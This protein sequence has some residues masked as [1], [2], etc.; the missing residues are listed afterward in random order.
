MVIGVIAAKIAEATAGVVSEIT[1][2]EITETVTGETAVEETTRVA[3][4]GTTGMTAAGEAP[5]EVHLQQVIFIMLNAELT[6]LQIISA[7]A[8]AEIASEVVPTTINV[9]SLHAMITPRH[10]GGE[11]GM[12]EAVAGMTEAMKPARGTVHAHPGTMMVLSDMLAKCQLDG[13]KS[14]LKISR[15]T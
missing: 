4:V 14:Q 3:A 2:R 11:T 9:R 15:R 12:V 13:T 8:T 6:G 1:A 7:G 5:E 10:V